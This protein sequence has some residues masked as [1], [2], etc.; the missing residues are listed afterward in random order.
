MGWKLLLPTTKSL[1]LVAIGIGVG[2]GVGVG[3]GG[4]NSGNN[5]KSSSSLDESF[6]LGDDGSSGDSG[7]VAIGIGVCVGVSNSGN[8]KSSSLLDESFISSPPSSVFS[9]IVESTQPMGKD[10]SS[11]ST[12]SDVIEISAK[13]SVSTESAILCDDIPLRTFSSEQETVSSSSSS[14]AVLCDNIPLQTVSSEELLPLDESLSNIS[15]RRRLLA[16]SRSSSCS[17]RTEPVNSTPI[18]LS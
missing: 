13:T 12:K 8:D 11:H 14:G 5:N 3:V 7:R 16:F 10:V 1:P 17:K 4:S 18:F 15:V 2:V 6:R 9:G